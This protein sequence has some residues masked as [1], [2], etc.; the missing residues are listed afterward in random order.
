MTPT[1]RSHSVHQYVCV[2]AYMCV[3]CDMTIHK[4]ETCVS[5]VVNGQDAC[6]ER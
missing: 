4:A 3:L 2:H 6:S 5:S 1:V